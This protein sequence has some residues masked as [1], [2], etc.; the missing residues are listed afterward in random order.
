[1]RE[2]ALYFLLFSFLGYTVVID[3]KNSHCTQD[4][5]QYPNSFTPYVVNRFL[6]WTQEFEDLMVGA[7]DFWCSIILNVMCK[8]CSKICL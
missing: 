1:M 7:T 6:I 8:L 5:D 4:Y 3:K 2:Q